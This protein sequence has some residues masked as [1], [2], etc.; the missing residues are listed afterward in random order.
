MRRLV[1]PPPSMKCDLCEGAL[2]LE[3]VEPDVHFVEV[4]VAIYICVKCGRERS[5]QVIHDPYAAHASPMRGPAQAPARSQAAA[6]S[7]SA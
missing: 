3:R 6:A 2:L 7:R 1:D 4:D 5:R